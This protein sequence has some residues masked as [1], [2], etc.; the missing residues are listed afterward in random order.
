VKRDE[1]R[2]LKAP[3]EFLLWTTRASDWARKNQRLLIGAGALGALLVLVVGV[4]SWQAARRAGTANE[5]FRTARIKFVS[6]QFAGAQADFEIVARDYP[7]TAFGSLAVLYRGHSLLRQADAAA[8]VGAYREYLANP[9]AADYLRQLALTNL[10]LAQEQTGDTQAA[11]TTLGE[12]VEISGPY[13][14]AGL[15]AYARLAEA[16]GDSASAATAYRKVLEDDPDPEVR[17][18]VQRHLPPEAA[19]NAK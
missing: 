12:A 7:S 2:S 9:L 13:R 5:A 11:R 10:A 19:A 4:L 3:D 16:A 1:R 17:T 6:G 8:A 14:V 18:T 15:L